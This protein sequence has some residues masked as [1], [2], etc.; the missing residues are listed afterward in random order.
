MDI[1]EELIPGIVDMRERGRE[2]FVKCPECGLRQKAKALCYITQTHPCL[3]CGHQITCD[4]WKTI[5]TQC[6]DRVVCPYCGYDLGRDQESEE[7]DGEIIE[8]YDCQKKFV[9]E[10][11]KTV[12]YS[13][14]ADCE[15][16]GD[17]H[18][19]QESK[20]R[21]SQ[22]LNHYNCSKC[23]M[24]TVEP[25]DPVEWESVQQEELGL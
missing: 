22:T 10:V 3:Q 16:N 9:L 4:E 5:H 20:S 15:L 18:E 1:R 24:S 13:A 25:K 12:E 8:C 17:T 19:W 14:L 2:E 11:E 23:D 7:S 21:T 6:T